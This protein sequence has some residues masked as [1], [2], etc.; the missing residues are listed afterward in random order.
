MRI[1]QVVN[2][3]GYTRPTAAGEPGIPTA[4]SG[5]KASKA[6]RSLLA[7]KPAA[8]SSAIPKLEPPAIPRKTF[9]ART[10]KDQYDI[11]YKYVYKDDALKIFLV[12][13]TGCQFF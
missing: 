9:K 3:H 5:V 7:P 10:S 12:I 6:K 8:V 4:S 2:D 11:S 13:F 1:R